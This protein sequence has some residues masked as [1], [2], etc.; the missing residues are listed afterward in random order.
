MLKSM[1]QY[2]TIAKKV[3][4]SCWCIIRWSLIYSLLGHVTCQVSRKTRYPED[5]GWNL[6]NM[7]TIILTHIREKHTVLSAKVSLWWS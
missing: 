4:V 2:L 1:A 5:F 7:V 3:S 6:Q